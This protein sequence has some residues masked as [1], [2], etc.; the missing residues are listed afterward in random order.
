MYIKWHDASVSKWRENVWICLHYI[1]NLLEAVIQCGCCD[2]VVR[3]C[4]FSG[5]NRN[6][7]GSKCLCGRNIASCPR[8]TVSQWKRSSFIISIM[9]GRMRTTS[10]WCSCSSSQLRRNVCMI[11]LPSAPSA[12]PGQQN[13]SNPTTPAPSPAGDETEVKHNTN[14][15]KHTTHLY[16]TCLRVFSITQKKT[17]W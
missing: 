4:V 2:V 3:V 15:W 1:F 7:S 12:C 17:F 13:S 16:W 9:L 5:P 8:Q 6:P 11:I 10:L 14:Q